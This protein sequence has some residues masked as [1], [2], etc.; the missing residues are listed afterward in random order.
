M[1]TMVMVMMVMKVMV[2]EVKI[3]VLACQKAE[4]SVS[5]RW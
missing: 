4:G 5:A 2:M 1:V 3:L